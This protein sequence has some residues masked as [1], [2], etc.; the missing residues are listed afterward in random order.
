MV[1][2]KE[3][4][5]RQKHELTVQKQLESGKPINKGPTG[6]QGDSSKVTSE[7]KGKEK[8]ISI[9]EPTPQSKQV[10]PSKEAF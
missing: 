3:I 6:G 8:G 9:K 4:I 2:I 1:S 5:A 7:S 10:V